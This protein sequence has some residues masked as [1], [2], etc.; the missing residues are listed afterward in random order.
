M[1]FEPAINA[2]SIQALPEV[3]FQGEIVVVDS[4]MLM[5]KLVPELILENV[6]GF[7]T[8]TKPNFKKGNPN[9]NT[10]SL[11]QLS[12]SEKTYLF[13]LKK[14][15]LPDILKHILSSKNIVKAGVAV[16]DDIIALRKIKPFNP[17]G[18]IDLQ[19]EAEK[20]GIIDKSLRKLS[21]IVLEQR[22]SKAQQLSNWENEQLNE[23]QLYYAAVDAWVCRQIFLKFQ[24]VENDREAD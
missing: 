20:Y 6:W 23:K 3:E 11:L 9:P 22:I 13:R 24:S 5:N 12:G 21:A 18:F 8:E 10:V 2:E 1:T 4:Q 7:D 19:I 14:I 15:G 16:R 17:G